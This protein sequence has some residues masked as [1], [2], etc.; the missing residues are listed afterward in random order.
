MS[1]FLLSF[2]AHFWGVLVILFF[3]LLDLQ[4]T[5]SCYFFYFKLFL[6]NPFTFL[7]LV[8]SVLTSS[9]NAQ[10]IFPGVFRKFPLQRHTYLSA[11]TLLH[12]LYFPSG[13]RY[14]LS[15]IDNT[16]SRPIG[17]SWGFYCHCTTGHFSFYWILLPSTLTG[18][19]KSTH[20]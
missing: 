11:R 7:K 6:N 5:H 18:V 9:W 3:W 2:L 19:S 20:R 8:S 4:T 14:P 13:Q 17:L 16:A 10:P 1:H 12:F 15:S